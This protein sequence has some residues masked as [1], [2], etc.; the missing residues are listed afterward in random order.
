MGN[1]RSEG[2]GGFGGRS[3][4][5]RF[6][7]G[8][9]FGD[10][11]GGKFERRPTEMHNAVCDQCKKECQVPF[12]PSSNKPVYCSE[13]F[14]EKENGRDNGSFSP[15]SQSRPSKS[16]ISSEQLNK[17]NAKLDR[18]LALLETLEIDDMNEDSEEDLKN[19]LN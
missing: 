19:D 10:R 18:I 14:K 5:S 2:K 8:R 1:F 11:G 17:I 7:G 12:R 4:G 16:G 9:N 3:G 13:C 6:G 15:R